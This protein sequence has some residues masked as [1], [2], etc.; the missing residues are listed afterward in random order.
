MSNL[1]DAVLACDV[2][3]THT[4]LEGAQLPAEDFWKIGHYFWL[5]REMKAAGYPA[6]HAEMAPDAR[7]EAYASA[8]DATRNTAMNRAMRA[9]VRDLY[10]IELTDAASVLEADEAVRESAAR[11]DWAAEVFEAAGV[12]RA[13]VNIEEDADFGD[14]SDIAYFLPRIERQIN[15][16]T[17]AIVESDAPG[18]AG[19]RVAGEIDGF[20]ADTS[21]RGIGGLMASLGDWCERTAGDPPLLASSTRPAEARTFVMHHLADAATR[22]GLFLQLFLGMERGW[23]SQ[24]TAHNRADRIIALHGLF[25]RYECRFDLVLSTNLLNFDSVQTARMFPNVHL[26]GLW[27]F[28]FRPSTYRDIMQ[29]RMEALPPAKSALIAS[30]ARCVE[31]CYAKVMLVKRLLAEFLQ[32]QVDRGWLD[33]DDA[34]WMAREWLHDSAM[35]LYTDREAL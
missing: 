31:W 9:A 26:G 5:L 28:N 8:L 29:Y 27:W 23:S 30:D 6:D 10:D 14:L 32:Q 34:L 11:S 4:H 17:N 20:A 33:E 1:R 12:R 15:S 13:V 21:G 7:A 3:D 35:R 24:V 25:E 19:E 16:W 2:W 22:H 18:D